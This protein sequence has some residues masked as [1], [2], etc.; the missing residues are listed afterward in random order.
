MMWDVMEMRKICGKEKRKE[1]EED[2][3]IGETIG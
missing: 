1:E 2:N 3:D